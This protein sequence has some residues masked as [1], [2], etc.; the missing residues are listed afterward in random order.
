MRTQVGGCGR[1]GWPRATSSRRV[2]SAKVEDF[3]DLIARIGAHAPG[4]RSL[5][6]Q[7]GGATKNVQVTLGSQPDKAATTDSGGES[8]NPFG[9]QGFP[10]GGGGN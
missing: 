3:A 1:P 4:R 8:Q 9:G 2:G 6:V 7:S 10:F 5:T